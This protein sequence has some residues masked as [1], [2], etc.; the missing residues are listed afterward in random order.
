VQQLFSLALAYKDHENYLE[1]GLNLLKK[2]I[3]SSID[4][5]GF[6]KSRNIK[7]LILYLKYFIIIRE[8]FKESQNVNSRI[9]R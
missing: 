9:Y 2:I 6:P 4:N 5:Q 3:R 8:W 1:N 7:Q